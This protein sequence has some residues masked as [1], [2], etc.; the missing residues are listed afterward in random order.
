M[1]QQAYT[2]LRRHGLWHGS[3]AE[4]VHVHASGRS[5]GE[6]TGNTRRKGSWNFGQSASQSNLQVP[7]GDTWGGVS[8]SQ[9]SDSQWLSGLL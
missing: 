8:T 4:G 1:G 2:P 7:Q 5:F 6:S 3:V 9:F